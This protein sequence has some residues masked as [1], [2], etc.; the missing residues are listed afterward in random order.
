VSVGVASGTEALD[1]ALF[2]QADR[3]LYAAK[4]LARS[5]KKPVKPF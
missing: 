4:A 1:N 2:T 3:A 5:S